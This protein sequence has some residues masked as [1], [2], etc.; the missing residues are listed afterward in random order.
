MKAISYNQRNGGHRKSLCPEALQ[1]PAQYQYNQVVDKGNF[2]FTEKSSKLRKNTRI[3]NHH[4]CH[5]DEEKVRKQ[6]QLRKSK[7]LEAGGWL[8]GFEEQL[9][10]I[11]GRRQIREVVGGRLVQTL[12]VRIL[13]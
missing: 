3:E 11:S 5:P 12:Q 1:G 10:E 4:F 2:L 7:A 8:A 6:K 9:N 13:V